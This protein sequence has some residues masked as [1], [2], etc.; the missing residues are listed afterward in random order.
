[1][2]RVSSYPFRDSY[3]TFVE[4]VE[5]N[6]RA[7]LQA[8]AKADTALLAGSD[9]HAHHWSESSCSLHFSNGRSLVVHVAERQIDWGVS[10]KVHEDTSS[11]RASWGPVTLSLAGLSEPLDFDPN[12]LLSGLHGS[13]FDQLYYLADVGW[14]ALYTQGNDPLAFYPLRREDTG[15]DMLYA[16]WLG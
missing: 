13:A 9:L 7:P 2:I 5:A 10:D 4:A 1:M 6:D 12:L 15:N 11:A 8:R 3:D 16:G 14:L